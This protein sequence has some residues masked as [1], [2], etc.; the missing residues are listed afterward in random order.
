M[1][2]TD[3]TSGAAVP[4]DADFAGAVEYRGARIWHARFGANGAGVERVVVLLHGGLGHSGNWGLQIPALRDAGFDVLTIDSRGHG[5]STRDD[6]PYSYAQMADDLLAVLDARGVSRAALVGWSDG[7]VTGLLAAMR[8]PERVEGLLYFACNV[9]PSGTKEFAMEPD[10]ALARC[11]AR[12]TIDYLELS[13]TPDDFHA[14]CEGVGQM[15]RTQPNLTADELGRVTVPVTVVQSEHDE[16][17]RPE[18]A[19]YLAATIPGAK[20]VK[21]VGVSHF[22]PLQRPEG[23]HAAVSAFLNG[24][25]SGH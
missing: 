13:A 21:L 22:A 25:R 11:F 16:F 23:F 7:A 6:M 5:R 10:S 17:I 14:F 8:A 19:A 2:F 15:Q 20:L 18:H 9:D 12:H 1:A 3:D 24:L 4:L